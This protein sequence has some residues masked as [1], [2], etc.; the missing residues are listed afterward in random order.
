MFNDMPMEALA[1]L[2]KKI[3]AVRADMKRM[4]KSGF[5]KEQNFPFAS[6]SDIYDSVRESMVEHGLELVASMVSMEQTEVESKRGAKGFH[7]VA[8]FQFTFLDT[9]S[10]ASISNEWFAESI[11]YGDKG[12]NKVA[13]AATKYF[14]LSVFLISTGEAADPDGESPEATKVIGR[15]TPPKKS[16][17][18]TAA[19]S[20]PAAYWGD[21]DN[22]QKLY[23]WASKDHGLKKEDINHILGVEALELCTM[24]REEVFA[25]INQSVLIAQDQNAEPF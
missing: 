25:A 24:T 2:Y 19:P 1:S 8:K 21:K 22:R 13:T 15:G 10:G 16:S 18:G 3:G 17:N 7:T 20:D 11:D 4:K 14:L 12:V 9:D 6:Y 23:I 5:N